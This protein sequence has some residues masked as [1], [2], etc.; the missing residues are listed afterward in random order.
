MTARAMSP[1]PQS[2][3][4]RK[5]AFNPPLVVVGVK[6]DSG[7]NSIVKN[8]KTFALYMLGKDGKGVA[9]SPACR[10]GRP[11]HRR[12]RGRR[13]AS[14]E[15]GDWALVRCDPRDEGSSA[16]TSST[17]V[18]AHSCLG[19]SG[20]VSNVK[21]LHLLLGRAKER[22]LERLKGSAQASSVV[23]YRVCGSRA[24]CHRTHPLRRRVARGKIPDRRSGRCFLRPR[25][26]PWPPL[27]K[28]CKSWAM[29]KAKISSSTRG[30]PKET[31]GDCRIW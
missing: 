3:G 26:R 9:K 4:S 20:L 11:P 24:L 25:R 27:C 31:W 23:G 14:G 18:D 13:C 30:R 29:S 12:R 17:G 6:T 22:Q 16:T 21:S 8:T 28:N 1:R 10:A 2:T 7:A 5:T 15:A 19:F